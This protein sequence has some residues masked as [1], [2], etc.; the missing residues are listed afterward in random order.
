MLLLFVGWRGCS[1]VFLFLI[2]LCL[3]SL[4]IPLLLFLLLLL[5]EF[6]LLIFLLLLPISSIASPVL[7]V[8]V[9]SRRCTSGAPSNFAS[10][11]CFRLLGLRLFV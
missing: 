6:L 11:D 9:C 3:L 5:L 7:Q 8:I 4:L 2:V 1:L 10:A